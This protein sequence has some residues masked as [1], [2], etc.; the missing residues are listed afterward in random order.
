MAAAEVMPLLKLGPF[1]GLDLTSA[2]PYVEPGYATSATNANP[3]IIDKA[4]TTERGR[5]EMADF[6]GTFTSVSVVV[7]V[8]QSSEFTPGMNGSSIPLYLVGGPTFSGAFGAVLYNPATGSSQTVTYSGSIP[9]AL[10]P[11]DQ[12]VQF[13]GVVYLNNGYR[14]FLN[15]QLPPGYVVGFRAWQYPPPVA[16]GNVTAVDTGAYSTG[17]V[18]TV[19]GG[20]ITTTGVPVT[21]TPAAITN[22][23][24]G[25]LIVIDSGSQQEI[26]TI[27]GVTGT[28]FDVTNQLLHDTGF[29]I[30]AGLIGPATFEY[31]FTRL[32]TNPDGTTSETSCDPKQFASPPAVA[33]G[34]STGSEVAVTC[35]NPLTW[36]GTNVLD[37]ST[38]TTN[39]YRSSTLQPTFFYVRNV[40]GGAG[41]GFVDVSPDT[42]ILGNAQLETRDQPPLV[43]GS[44]GTLPTQFNFGSI[45]I[46]KG[47]IWVYVIVQ[48]ISTLGVPEVQ[49][50]YSNLGRGWEFDQLNQVLLLQSDVVN[51]YADVLV[52]EGSTTYDNLYGND[53]LAVAECGTFLMAFSRRQTWAIYG[54]APANFLARQNFNIG[55]VSRHSVTPTTG[56]IFWLSE[57]GS[58]W[59]DGSTPQYID[60]GIRGLLSATPTSP[61]IQLSA[62]MQSTG[63][64]S[65]MTW[66]LAF[67]TL[68]FTIGYYTVTGKWLSQIGYAPAGPAAVAYTPAYSNMYAPIAGYGGV[69]EVIAARKTLTTSVDWWFADPNFD[70][71]GAQGVEWVGPA[72]YCGEDKDGWEKVFSH[73]TV[74]APAQPGTV[75]VTL[76]VDPNSPTAKTRTFNFDLSKGTRQISSVG[77]GQG[78]VLRGFIAQ[79]SVFMLG[80]ANPNP[81]PHIWKVTAWGTMSRNLTIPV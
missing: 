56:G 66:Y 68:D 26:L 19:A 20:P 41:T 25:N 38:F 60:G 40:S 18:A 54:D 28:T 55:C 22:I 44:Y 30:Q 72:T 78:G 63:F 65:N 9:P 73:I 34:S 36:S 81:A 62:Q 52:L 23:V 14:L 7:P 4:L 16:F 42:A 76:T 21:I 15:Q 58:Y 74:T 67:P 45:S 59:F 31:L 57:N 69:N 49:L 29:I 8:M 71:G 37:G 70:L 50:W 75:V 24:N 77:D 10:L 80:A 53:P 17:L 48:N 13:G 46:H 3:S 12:A 64:F 2:G 1:I 47:R 32:T 51:S 33:I 6:S 43:P 39:V 27:S 79:L 61:A 5:V 35:Q 11:F